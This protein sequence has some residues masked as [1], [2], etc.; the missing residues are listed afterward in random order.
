MKQTQRKKAAASV[1]PAATPAKPLALADVAE[2][3]E[4]TSVGDQESPLR[5]VDIEGSSAAA[6]SSVAPARASESH[7]Y[8]ISAS[9]T[10]RDSI[11]MKSSLLDLLMDQHPVT[12]DVRAVERVDTA[13]LQVLCAF[14]RD[15]KAAGGEV[16]WTGFTESFSEAIR[17]LGLQQA[18]GLTDAQ[19]TGTAI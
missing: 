5:V 8:A 4:V 16:I 17:L 18:L 3:A 1:A 2:V 10:I 13:A 6:L 15:R 19:L 7:T 9:C 14:V 11:E 12:I